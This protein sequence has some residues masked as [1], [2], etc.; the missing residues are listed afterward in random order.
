MSAAD[1]AD[2]F[3]GL[4]H[5]L[6]RRLLRTLGEDELS[7]GALLSGLKLTMPALSQHLRVLREAGLVSHRK[8]GHQRLYRRNLS[9]LRRARRWLEECE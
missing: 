1:R 8:E 3:R 6:R 7:V 2:V 4:S 9:M 5:P